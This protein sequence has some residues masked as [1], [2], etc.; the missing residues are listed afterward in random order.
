VRCEDPV[1]VP[2][3]L[4]Y[5]T[6][7]D[8]DGNRLQP[9]SGPPGKSLPARP[10]ITATDRG[11]RAREP[12]SRQHRFVRG[13]PVADIEDDSEPR[14]R[15]LRHNREGVGPSR[16]GSVTVTTQSA[17]DC[18]GRP[19]VSRAGLSLAM[20]VGAGNSPPMSAACAG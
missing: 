19:L 9:I 12:S 20:P 4:T 15:G 17:T 2:G 8:P 1:D 6:F 5:C 7:Y 18:W 3:L 10:V 14:Y 13:A 16:A 11:S